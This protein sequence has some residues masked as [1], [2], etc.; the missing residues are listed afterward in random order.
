VSLNYE[1]RSSWDLKIETVDQGGKFSWEI[2]DN[3]CCEM[4]KLYSL[5]ISIFREH[6]FQFY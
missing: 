1:N 3:K 4:K 5:Y 2:F 6:T